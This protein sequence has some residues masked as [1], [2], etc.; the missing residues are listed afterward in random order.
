MCPD[1]K[2]KNNHYKEVNF[3]PIALHSSRERQKQEIKKLAVYNGD[4]DSPIALSQES[5]TDVIW[6]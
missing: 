3:D 1:Y 5:T 4:Y 2:F 6:L